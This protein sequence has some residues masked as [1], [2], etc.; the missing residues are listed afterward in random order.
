[1][2]GGSGRTLY[3]NFLKGMLPIKNKLK[4]FQH[5]LSIQQDILASPNFGI[6]SSSL[7]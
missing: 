4:C 2:L 7:R 6:L 5:L 1:M 3:T